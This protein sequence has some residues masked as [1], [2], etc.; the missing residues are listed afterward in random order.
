MVA[1]VLIGKAPRGQGVSADIAH[2]GDDRDPEFA[3]WATTATVRSRIGES[4]AQL[5]ESVVPSSNLARAAHPEMV[6][7]VARFALREE[8]IWTWIG[9]YA[10]AKFAGNVRDGTYVGAGVLSLNEQMPAHA[11]LIYVTK[12]LQQI[13]RQMTDGVIYNPVTEMVASGVK[14]SANPFDV[15]TF[16]L[17][18][19]LNS[20]S[21]RRLF[22]DLS[23]ISNKDDYD[24]EL[25]RLLADAQEAG[26]F[27]T[28]SELTIGNSPSLAQRAAGSGRYKVMTSL[29][30]YRQSTRPAAANPTQQSN[31][32]IA[33]Q[34]PRPQAGGYERTA[35][36]LLGSSE[37]DGRMLDLLRQDLLRVEEKVDRLGVHRRTMSTA[38]SW[39]D[40][41]I[42]GSSPWHKWAWIAVVLVLILIVGGWMAWTSADHL[43]RADASA[44]PQ[45]SSTLAGEMAATQPAAVEDAATAGLS[46]AGCQPAQTTIEN[47]FGETEIALAKAEIDCLRGLRKIAEQRI[48]ELK[49]SLPAAPAAPPP[50]ADE[51]KKT[52]IPKKKTPPKDAAK[53]KKAEGGGGNEAEADAASGTAD[54]R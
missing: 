49:K 7:K 27:N 26:R 1:T 33:G 21:P 4:W 38:S 36:R 18:E 24:R 3:K 17:E 5:D 46:I 12:L 15:G 8:Q 20:Q 35:E 42:T 16:R 23:G 28:I 13:Q 44:E 40:D 51:T 10:A 31:L 39:P 41:A 37:R 47:R 22:I 45:Q 6:F 53:P 9:C 34:A 32:H 43:W 14:I 11:A 29:D 30:W 19:G 2:L 50:S 25:I 48:E 52:T 54:K